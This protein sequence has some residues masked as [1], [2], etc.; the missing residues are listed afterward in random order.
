ML[1]EE[2]RILP[3]LSRLANNAY[4]GKIYEGNDKG[5]KISRYQ[6]DQVSYLPCFIRENLYKTMPVI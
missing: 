1:E 2:N 6:L 4:M 5:E 3:R